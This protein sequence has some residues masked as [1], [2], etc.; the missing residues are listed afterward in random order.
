MDEKRAFEDLAIAIIAKAAD[1]YRD[2]LR[3]GRKRRSKECEQ[4]FKSDFYRILT[5]VEGRYVIQR[6]R[7][8]IKN[9]LCE[10]RG[11]DTDM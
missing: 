4:F 11:T 3:R 7:E 8:E 9:E 1:D 10:G 2:Y 5:R 6:I